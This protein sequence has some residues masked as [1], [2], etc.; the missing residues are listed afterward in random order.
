MLKI[1]KKDELLMKSAHK[2]EKVGVREMRID[3]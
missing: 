3:G 1:T 2:V